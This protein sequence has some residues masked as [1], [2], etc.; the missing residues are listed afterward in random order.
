MDARLVRGRTRLLAK[1]Q[2]IADERDVSKRLGNV[3]PEETVRIPR[4]GEWALSEKDHPDAPVR[5]MDPEIARRLRPFPRSIPL[6]TAQRARASKLSENPPIPTIMKP[7]PKSNAPLPVHAP[8]GVPCEIT[9]APIPPPESRIEFPAGTATTNLTDILRSK[10]MIPQRPAPV[11]PAT[12][13]EDPKFLPLEV[14]D[15]TANEEFS[16][17]ELMKDPVAYSNSPRIL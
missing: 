13:A 7:R 12:E 1:E 16:V 10:C 11:N 8:K 15:D 4:I 5:E 6:N 17:E 2:A 3:L 14:F 9:R